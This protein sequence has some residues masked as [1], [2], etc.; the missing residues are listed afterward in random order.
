[1]MILNFQFK[2]KSGKKYL[3]TM[4]GELFMES[5]LIFFIDGILHL[6]YQVGYRI[7]HSSFWVWQY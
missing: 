2:I 1:M 4:G 7:T 6:E 3:E 5:D